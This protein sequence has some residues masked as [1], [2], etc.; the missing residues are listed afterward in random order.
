MDPRIEVVDW[1]GRVARLL[2][3]KGYMVAGSRYITR[4]SV[5]DVLLG[6]SKHLRG[7]SADPHAITRRPA[8]VTKTRLRIGCHVF[9]GPNF[10]TIKEWAL[11]VQ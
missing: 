11:G 10:R 4:A 3:T 8:R 7:G 1:K 2:K 6:Q 5:R 9:S